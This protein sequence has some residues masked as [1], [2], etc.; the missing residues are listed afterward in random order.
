M[1]FA[2]W[3]ALEGATFTRDDTQYAE[4]ANHRGGVYDSNGAILSV[5]ARSSPHAF[6]PDLF[7][8]ALLG[9]FD[10]YYPGYSHSSRRTPTA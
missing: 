1:D 4:W 3:K 5:I 9:R 10:G 7:L 6:S 2:A 8:Y